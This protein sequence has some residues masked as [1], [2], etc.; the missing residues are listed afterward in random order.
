MKNYII[1]LLCFT[2]NT[3]NIFGQ[4]FDIT[5]DYR[6]RYEMRN[7][8]ATLKPDTVNPA[9]FITQR[10]RITFDYSTKNIKL[11]FSPQNVKVWGDIATTS[12]NDLYNSFHEASGEILFNKY[13][14]FKVGRQEL[15]YDDARVLGNVDWAMQ[16]RSHDAL[17]LKIKP[18]SN[19]TIHAGFALNAN[20]ETNFQENYI[21]GQY[22]ALQ[23]LWYHNNIKNWRVSILLLN[24]G[25]PY[26]V[27][28]KEKIAY[29]QTVGGSISYKKNKFRTEISAYLQKGK[30]GLNIV[31][32]SNFSLKTNY[33]ITDN[34]ITEFGVEYLSGK[35]TNDNSPDIKSFNPLYGTNHKFNGYMDYFFVGNHL[36]TVGLTDIYLNAIFEKNKF[37][38]T[39]TPHYFA[40]AANLYNGNVKMDKYLGTEADF[41][42]GYKLNENIKID[43]GYSQIFAAESMEVLKGGNK[44]NANNWFY[45]MLKINPKVFSYRTETILK[46]D[47]P[48]NFNRN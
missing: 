12:K 46:N 13:Y 18:D 24:N 25:M 47:T 34:L 48:T 21:V 43:V 16:A 1:L 14:S 45:L 5:A 2:F 20:K 22:K 4:Q 40:G 27:D 11:R 28:S 42:L 30:L 17:L 7:G 10:A 32:A 31:N 3:T 39:L 29:S 8:Y 33:K 9:N 41:T 36:Y 6:V 26:I 23:F 15:D 38:A 35:A 44:S 37:S 19:N